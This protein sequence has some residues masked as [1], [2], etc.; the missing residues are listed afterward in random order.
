[1]IPAS[2]LRWVLWGVLAAVGA[3]AFLLGGLHY[4]YTV[5]FGVGPVIRLAALAALVGAALGL[6]LA[7]ASRRIKGSKVGAR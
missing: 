1:V 3:T 7:W 2:M 5:G 6:S 4:S